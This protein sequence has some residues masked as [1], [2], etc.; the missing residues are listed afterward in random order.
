MRKTKQSI[1][2]LISSSNETGI[3]ITKSNNTVKLEVFTIIQQLFKQDQIE[4]YSVENHSLILPARHKDMHVCSLHGFVPYRQ[5]SAVQ[6]EQEAVTTAGSAGRGEKGS[7]LH[8]F[9][10]DLGKEKPDSCQDKMIHMLACRCTYYK[11][12]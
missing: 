6:P 2:S 5:V 9:C 8:S 11:Y 4:K 1:Y 3:C 12:S 7:F 10:P